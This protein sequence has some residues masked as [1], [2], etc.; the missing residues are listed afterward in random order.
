MG[1]AC[2]PPRPASRTTAASHVVRDLGEW[3][4]RHA[5]EV[6]KFCLFFAEQRPSAA[7]RSRPLPGVCRAWRRYR[8][9]P[10]NVEVTAAGVDKGERPAGSGRPAGHPPRTATLAVGDSDNDRAMLARAGVA[11][12]MANALPEIRALGD[13]VSTGRQCNHDGV[14]EVFETLG[15]VSL[16]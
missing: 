6:E 15:L 1:S 13:L 2:T 12:V 16:F 10:E 3:M 7:G 14:A 9:A 11:A 8:A 5:H 4:S